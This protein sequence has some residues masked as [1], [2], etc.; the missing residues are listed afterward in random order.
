MTK[1]KKKPSQHSLDKIADAR[2]RNQFFYKLN[3]LITALTGD[4]SV[5]KLIPQKEYDTVFALRVRAPRV[6]AAP[7][8][9]LNPESIEMIRQLLFHRFKIVTV[10]YTPAGPEITLDMF[11]T[12]GLFLWGYLSVLEDDEY[13]AAAELKKRLAIVTDDS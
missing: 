5:F 10:N 6:K 4:P 2:R 1:R 3:Y 8:N 11:F 7:D 12:V 13:P 9:I